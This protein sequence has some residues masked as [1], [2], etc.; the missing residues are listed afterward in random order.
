MTTATALPRWDLTPAFA[1]PGAPELDAMLTG[2]RRKLV[3]LNEIVARPIDNGGIAAL[4]TILDRSNDVR[5]DLELVNAFLYA[6]YSADTSDQV[7]A[8]KLSDLYEL[9]A[10]A[11]V[12]WVRV[13]SRL[14]VLDVD[15]AVER[16]EV[17]RAHEHYLRTTVLEAGHL[18]SMAEEELAAKLRPG[19]G[20]AWERL[21]EDVASAL[22]S[23]FELEGE[24]R[25]RPISEIMNLNTHPDRDVRRRAYEVE[26]RLWNEAAVSIAASLNGIKN[27]ALVLSER[28]GWA[29]PL[30]IAL[31]QNAIDRPV[32]EAMIGAMEG[33]YGELRG[34][35]RRKARMLGVERLAWYDLLAPL[36]TDDTTYSFDA[37]RTLLRDTVGGLSPRLATMLDRAFD[38]R[39]V[40]A[41]PRAGKYGGAYCTELFP[42]GS[43]ILMNFNGSLSAVSTLAHELG[44]AFHN[45]CIADRTPLQRT[46]PMTLAE[47]ASMLLQHMLEDI[48]LDRA[49]DG[50]K[51]SILNARLNDAAS[52]VFDLRSRFEFEKA[53][54]S[55]RR[56]R[57]LTVDELNQLTLD[58]QEMAFGDAL[59]PERRAP[60]RW[61]ARSH[62]YSVDLGYYNFPYQFGLLFALGLYQRYLADPVGFAEPYERLLSRTGMASAVDLASEFGIDLTEEAFWASS[63]DH[64]RGDIRRFAELTPERG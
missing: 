23:T 28:R 46:L 57:A 24:E 31:H 59:D 43:R 52:I 51:L 37:A 10:V 3:E 47:T 12:T 64:I 35:L 54:F 20:S 34:H 7:A 2:I 9:T 61:A 39:W 5:R 63:L 14:G 36:G 6:W 25:E 16:S 45:L 21:R 19:S 58:A 33:I 15:D 22:T 30:D 27:E 48:L 8:A 18:M 56:E 11:E 53:L 41:E 26:G 38:E 62:Y 13:K 44:H 42:H 1:S 40:D 4:E 17:A 50:G 60:Y 49:A 32:L 55:A 29:D